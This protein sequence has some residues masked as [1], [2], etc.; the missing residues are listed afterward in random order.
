MAL[1]CAHFAIAAR[2]RSGAPIEIVWDSACLNG[3]FWTLPTGAANTDLVYRL[4]DF[5]NGDAQQLGFAGALKCGPVT[6]SAIAKVP[7]A[8]APL[9]PTT[10]AN[11]RNAWHLSGQF[12]HDHGDEFAA[13]FRAI[14]GG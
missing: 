14:C 2:E 10:P 11:Q 9:I 1:T 4:I 13:R 8:L 12:W 3:G 7:P 5:A 6:R